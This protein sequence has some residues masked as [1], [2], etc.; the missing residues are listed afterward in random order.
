VFLLVDGESV[1]G[2]ASSAAPGVIIPKPDGV[3]VAPVDESGGGI[4]VADLAVDEVGDFR[5]RDGDVPK[6]GFLGPRRG[7]AFCLSRSWSAS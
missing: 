5:A 2:R 1:A 4:A 7:I 6:L 3:A